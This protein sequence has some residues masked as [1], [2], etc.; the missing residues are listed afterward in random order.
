MSEQARKD[1]AKASVGQGSSS[2]KKQA[3]PPSRPAQR[4]DLGNTLFGA[5]ASQQAQASN[6]FASTTSNSSRT[7]PFS[8]ATIPQ[9]TVESL[10]ATFAQKA[11]ISEKEKSAE[12]RELS[13]TSK[14]SPSQVPRVSWPDLSQQAKPYPRYFLDAEYEYISPT[15]N[16]AQNGESASKVQ[17][18]EYELDDEMADAGTGSR[19]SSKKKESSKAQGSDKNELKDSTHDKTFSHFASILDQN[20]DQVLRYEFGGQPLL[21]NSRDTVGRLLNTSKTSSATVSS[22]N[23]GPPRCQ[24][25]GASRSFECQLTPHAISELEDVDG[26]DAAELL[27]EGMEWGTIIVY[28]CSKDCAGDFAGN[29]K[30]G[31][32]VLYVEEWAGV[33]WEEQASKMS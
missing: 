20:P 27:A 8:A 29:E 4:T 14:S 12:P 10:P 21:Y 25:C 30:E 33:Q 6:P 3:A 1:S 7:N 2:S 22:S 26:A 17:L 15:S 16:E 13:T 11:Q 18:M 23:K 32:E 19:G 31:E 5:T 28:V 24:K 9:I